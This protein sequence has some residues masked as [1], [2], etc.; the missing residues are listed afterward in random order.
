MM[1]RFMLLATLICPTPKLE[2]TSK[3]KW[4]DRDQKTYE[5]IKKNFCEIRFKEEN[6]LALFRKV[7]ED[8]YYVLCTKP[9]EK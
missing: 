2:N 1:L 6:C 9:V 3:D 8:T 7:S 5:R 4:N